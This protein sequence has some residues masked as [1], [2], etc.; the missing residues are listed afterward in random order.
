MLP[1]KNISGGPEFDYFTDG[2][3]EDIITNLSKFHNLFVISRGSS[4]VYKDRNLPAKQI[5]RELDVRYIAEGSVRKAGNRMRISVQLV[6]TETDQTLWTERYDR[7]L[8]DIFEVQDEISA[9]I[10]NATSVKISG[11]ENFR[12]SRYCPIAWE[13]MTTC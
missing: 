4:F 10:C 5:G 1:F 8:D 3:T 9:I 7:N 12:L 13:P 11:E 2:V 6:D